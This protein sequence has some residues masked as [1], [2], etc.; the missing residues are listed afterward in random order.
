MEHYGSRWD[1]PYIEP[2][3]TC[4][5]QRMENARNPRKVTGWTMRGSAYRN[6]RRMPGC[7]LL[8]LEGGGYIYYA[9]DVAIG[10]A[11]EDAA[12]R[13]F[14]VREAQAKIEAWIRGELP[15]LVSFNLSE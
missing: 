1:R 5:M 3:P 12:D 10:P 9:E 14:D 15:D 4:D 13:G 6:G 2:I 11:L 8:Y 7:T